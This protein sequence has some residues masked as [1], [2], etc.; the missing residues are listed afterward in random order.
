MVTPHYHYGPDI[1]GY[2]YDRW[3]TYHRADR[4]GLGVDRTPNGTGY[5]T[6]YNEPWCTKYADKK[7]CPQELLLFFH[8]VRYDEVLSSGKTLIQHIYDTHFEGVNEVEEMIASWKAWKEE[9]AEDV[10][11]RVLSRMER[12][13]SNAIEWRDRVNTYFYR[14]SGVKDALS[15]KIYEQD[16]LDKVIRNIIRKYNNKKRGY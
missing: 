9:M 4:N 11:E 8:Y 3:G 10:Y 16:D 2:E 5:T 13:L 14:K 15:R 7:Q 12:Q 1:D 6:Q